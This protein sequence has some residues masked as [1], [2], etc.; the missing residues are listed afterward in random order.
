MAKVK[1]CEWA[2]TSDLEIQCHDEEWGTP[3]HD[4]QGLFEF[5]L[6]A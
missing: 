6:L 5:L 1:R 4:D 2:G 3:L